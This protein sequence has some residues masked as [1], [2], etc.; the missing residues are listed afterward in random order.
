MRPA[1]RYVVAVVVGLVAV[2]ASGGLLLLGEAV[3]HDMGYRVAFPP[4]PTIL[5]GP[6][7]FAND[8]DTEL[9]HYLVML[10]PILA[11]GLTAAAHAL[12]P[13]Q[14]RRR[15][16]GWRLAFATVMTLLGALY[17]S[18]NNF[19]YPWPI[20]LGMNV[21]V[22]VVGAGLAVTLGRAHADTAAARWLTTVAAGIAL[23]VAAMQALFTLQWV[24]WATAIVRPPLGWLAMTVLSSSVAVLAA[25]GW[26]LRRVARD[27]PETL[28][29]EV[30]VPAAG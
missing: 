11:A 6:M 10:S 24:V 14:F 1:V 7:P 19:Q 15:I 8:P 4:D 16:R 5:N 12:S 28:A 17:F 27:A 26:H 20:P 23:F 22:I 9:Y 21:F 29:P 30:V 18:P 2:V 25:R 13:G 3:I